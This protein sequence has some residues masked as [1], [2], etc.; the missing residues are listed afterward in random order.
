MVA[1]FSF[2]EVGFDDRALGADIRIF[3]DGENT[4]FYE[5][6]DAAGELVPD[7]AKFTV[8]PHDDVKFTGDGVDVMVVAGAHNEP[9]NASHGK[10]AFQGGP[11]KAT[12]FLEDG[13]RTETKKVRKAHDHKS[14]HRINMS[15][16]GEELSVDAAQVSGPVSNEYGSHVLIPAIPWGTPVDG[17]PEPDM[18]VED[19]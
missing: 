15:C 13:N 17:A 18:D 11:R 16:L 6:K 14:T 1:A 9:G 12:F 19:P 10:P 8:K 3:A 4:C 7:Q 5:I 2:P